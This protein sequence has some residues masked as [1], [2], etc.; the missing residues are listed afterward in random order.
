[1]ADGARGR[2]RRRD[3]RRRD[4]VANFESLNPA[5]THW[6]KPYN[7]YSKVDTEPSGFSSSRL[8]GATRSC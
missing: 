6:S 5:N 4:L 7:V 2:S 1:M 8:G 3:I